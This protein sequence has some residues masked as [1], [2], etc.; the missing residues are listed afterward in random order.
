MDKK[1]DLFFLIILVLVVISF[2]I[3]NILKTLEN[4]IIKKGKENQ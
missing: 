3:L 4:S 2:V 1:S